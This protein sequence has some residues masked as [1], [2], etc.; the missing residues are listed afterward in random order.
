MVPDERRL[1][2]YFFCAFAMLRVSLPFRYQLSRLQPVHDAVA[3]DGVTSVV[4]GLKGLARTSSMSTVKMQRLGNI[5]M[6]D[7]RALV[8]M[9]RNLSLFTVE[10]CQE[11]HYFRIRFSAQQ[12]ENGGRKVA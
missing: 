5:H 6:V 8:R 7:K 1:R 9:K 2:F 10:R 11:L 3:M 12:L 4:S